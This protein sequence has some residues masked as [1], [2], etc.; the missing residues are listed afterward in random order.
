MQEV[1]YKTLSRKREKKISDGCRA[2]REH[3]FYEDK[4]HRN[5]YLTKYRDVYPK[6]AYPQVNV[7]GEIR[8]LLKP[9]LD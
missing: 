7:D 5:P 4:S 8:V 6:Y 1:N 3:S 9:L 2:S